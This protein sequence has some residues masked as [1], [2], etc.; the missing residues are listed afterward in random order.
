MGDPEGLV[1]YDCKFEGLDFKNSNSKKTLFFINNMWARLLN[2]KLYEIRVIGC[3][4]NYFEENII[5]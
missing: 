3:L 5:E 1:L 2:K 4:L